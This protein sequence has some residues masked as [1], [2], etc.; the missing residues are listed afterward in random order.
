MPSTRRVLTLCCISNVLVYALVTHDNV[1]RKRRNIDLITLMMR[2]MI[3]HRLI[4]ACS[5]N[6]M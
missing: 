1:S 6:L 2:I 4:A 5:Y 3:V